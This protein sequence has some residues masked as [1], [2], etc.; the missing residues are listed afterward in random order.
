[1]KPV[2]RIRYTHF[3]DGFDEDRCRSHV[4]MDLCD[5]FDFVFCDDPDILLVGCYDSPEGLPSTK[6]VK[7]GY[8]TENLPPDL[9]NFDYFFGCEYSDVIGSPRYCKRIFGPL[10]SELLA[11]CTDPADA[12]ARKTRFCNFI[13]SAR[14]PFRER[15]FREL[16]R[17]RTIAAPGG[18]MRNCTDLSARSSDNWQ[19]DKLSYLGD[20]KFTIAFEN[21]RRIGYA[22][23]KLWDALSADTVPI[24]WG[25]PNIHVVLNREAAIFVEGDWEKDVLPFLRLPERRMPYRPYNR[26]PTLGN[27]LAGRCND[28]TSWLRAR[29]PYKKGFASA[30]EEI[31]ALDRDDDAYMSK[32]S[33]P[34]LSRR[35]LRMRE[36]YF[37]F[38]RRI[39]ADCAPRVQ[40]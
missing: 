37:E 33:Q 14:V 15:F 26:E 35:I 25:D 5:E 32:L 31:I 3:F 11:G 36:E 30:I 17:Y 38:W 1:M 28:L 18:A 6:A 19:K 12:L 9:V 39:I 4:L 34:R 24:Y 23:E 13:Y 21:S 10:Q 16:T 8:Y 7:I 20:F 2:V 40:V 29:V 27:K 22:T